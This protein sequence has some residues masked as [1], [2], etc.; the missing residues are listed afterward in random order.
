MIA[1]PGFAPDPSALGTAAAAPRPGPAAPERGPGFA[2]LLHQTQLKVAPAPA[3]APAPA[4]PPANGDETST[5]SKPTPPDRPRGV[6]RPVPRSAAASPGRAGEPDPVVDRLDRDA[7]DDASDATTDPSLAPGVGA[8]P[9]PTTTTAAGVTAPA[10]PVPVAQAPDATAAGVDLEA[11][12][13]GPGTPRGRA[14]TDTAARQA[15]VAEAADT[16]H[17]DA[18]ALAT[19]VPGPAGAFAR[20]LEALQA[21]A[22]S[23]AE[24][25]LPPAEA[26]TT[27]PPAAATLAG[28]PAPA[29]REASAPVTVAL[30][31]PAASPEF[32]Q[33]LGVQVSLLARDGVQHAELHLN[34]A[35]TGPVSVQIV[36]DGTQARVDFG[37]DLASTRQAI[38]ASLPGLAAALRDAGLTLSGGGVSQHA[39]GRGDPGG[40]GRRGGPEPRV[41]AAAAAADGEAPARTLRL[42]GRIGG[43]DLYA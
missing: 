6:P 10:C 9:V 23:A 40:D 17:A 1:S 28:T 12:G 26:T 22:A 34:P 39:R 5:A 20:Q 2:A 38:E 33:A 43:L 35:E 16:K 13:V 14:P 15:R 7:A 25:R 42:P 24:P 31:T 18:V 11:G 29:V 21:D 19:E 36:V 37:A 3:A 4:E 41:G 27:P 8:P 30:P 32:P